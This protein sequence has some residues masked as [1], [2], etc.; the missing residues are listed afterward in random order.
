MAVLG[1]VL[2]M[3]DGAVAI[4]LAARDGP[5]RKVAVAKAVREAG[6][7]VAGPRGRPSGAVGGGCSGWGRI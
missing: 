5:V 4:A 6:A 3:S 2:G 1:Y 7:A